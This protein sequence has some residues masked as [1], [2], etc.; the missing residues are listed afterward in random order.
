MPHIPGS[1]SQSPISVQLHFFYTVFMVYDVFREDC[2]VVANYCLQHAIFAFL[3]W[4]T[5]LSMRWGRHA[6][7]MDGVNHYSPQHYSWLDSIQGNLLS[8]HVCETRLVSRIMAEPIR[9]RQSHTIE[10]E[11]RWKS[12]SWKTSPECLS[13]VSNYSSANTPTD[14]Q[15]LYHLIRALWKQ[16]R[17]WHNVTKWVKL[18]DLNVLLTTGT[19]I[20]RKRVT[21]Q[22]L[23]FLHWAC[24]S[25]RVSM[26]PTVIEQ[27][28]AQHGELQ[29]LTANQLLLLAPSVFKALEELLLT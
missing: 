12:R 23:R 11:P 19:V 24:S 25:S 22:S 1:L 27:N 16:K 8:Y 3:D 6:T 7:L 2:V 9:Q 13:D 10:I 15:L 4:E 20:A 26:S 28:R 29:M 17:L 18:L 21:K 14:L 5:V